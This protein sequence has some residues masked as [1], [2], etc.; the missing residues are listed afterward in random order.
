MSLAGGGVTGVERAVGDDAGRKSR[1]VSARANSDAT[2]NLT[3]A[4][5]GHG[6]SAED[7]EILG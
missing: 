5:I 7:G 4:A 3:G 6:G 1:D 2:E